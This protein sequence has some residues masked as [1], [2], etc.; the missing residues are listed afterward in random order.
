[1]F[2]DVNYSVVALKTLCQQSEMSIICIAEIPAKCS[3]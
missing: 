3:I 2:Y 1:M